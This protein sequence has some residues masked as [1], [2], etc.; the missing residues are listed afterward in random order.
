MSPCCL[1][2]N[3][4]TLVRASVRMGPFN[5]L[6][7]IG[8]MDRPKGIP[9]QTSRGI[10]PTTV[11]QNKRIKLGGV[12]ESLARNLAGPNINRGAV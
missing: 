12:R 1:L 3:H 9:S 2:Y 5:S 10:S 4:L 11:A 6:D 7:A 8:R